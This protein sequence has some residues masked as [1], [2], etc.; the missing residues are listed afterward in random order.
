[1]KQPNGFYIFRVAEYSS[2]TLEELKPTLSTQLKDQKFQEWLRSTQDSVEVKIDDPA[3]FG[4]APAAP[5]PAPAAAPAATPKPT[6]PAATPKP[7]AP[8]AAPK[9]P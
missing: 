1:V 2:Q 4:K 9:K 6:A 5:A 3:F 7:A 8:R